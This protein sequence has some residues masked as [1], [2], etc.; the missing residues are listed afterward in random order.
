METNGPLPALRACVALKT[1]PPLSSPGRAMVTGTQYKAGHWTRS[2]C[3]LQF[4]NSAEQTAKNGSGLGR[5][6]TFSKS[7]QF[8]KEGKKKTAI[9]FDKYGRFKNL[10]MATKISESGGC[11]V[12]A[13]S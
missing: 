7:C 3:S 9:I 4:V 5:S 13:V 10:A 11:F 12:E 2:S 6:Q 8:R 1:W